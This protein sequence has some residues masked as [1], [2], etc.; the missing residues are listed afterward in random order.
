ME[1]RE[2]IRVR[3]TR[4]L[5]VPFRG[6]DGRLARQKA[7]EASVLE[8]AN[9]VAAARVDELRR[10]DPVRAR[11]YAT[12]PYSEMFKKSD[13][14]RERRLDW[15]ID[16]LEKSRVQDL[17]ESKKQRRQQ[18]FA[19]AGGRLLRPRFFGTKKPLF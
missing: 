8:N 19:A 4:L 2:F 11:V 3:F 1:A 13:P 17:V 7:I 15:E 9:R 14:Q 5:H 6:L 18:Q 16:M 10:T 12:I